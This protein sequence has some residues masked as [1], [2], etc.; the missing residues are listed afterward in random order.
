[1]ANAPSCEAYPLFLAT[2]YKMWFRERRKPDRTTVAHVITWVILIPAATTP[3]YLV[4]NR[5]IPGL[6]RLLAAADADPIIALGGQDECLA[7]G[8]LVP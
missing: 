1:M 8:T 5:Q 4:D 2:N 3:I 6:A 7:F